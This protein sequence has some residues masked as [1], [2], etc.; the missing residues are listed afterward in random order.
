MRCK[1]KTVFLLL[2][3]MLTSERTFAGAVEA[4]RPREKTAISAAEMKIL[5]ECFASIQPGDSTALLPH[6]PAEVVQFCVAWRAIRSGL[7][8]T[9][10][11]IP[12][13]ST[14]SASSTRRGLGGMWSVWQRQPPLWRRGKSGGNLSLWPKFA[15][16]A[17]ALFFAIFYKR[18][19]RPETAGLSQAR[20]DDE[21]RH[22]GA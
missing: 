4:V 17:A 9:L 7:L 20:S 19:A 1:L 8:Q 12:T 15:S 6:A 2:V 21:T 22:R 11:S 5:A 18:R 13:T 3:G 14:L 10:I 16:W